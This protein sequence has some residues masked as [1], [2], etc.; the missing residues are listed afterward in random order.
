MVPG[1]SMRTDFRITGPAAPAG[2]ASEFDLTIVAPT[3]VDALRVPARVTATSSSTPIQDAVRARLLAYLREVQAAKLK[4]YKDRTATRFIPL[5]MTSG[6]TLAPRARLAFNHW[7]SLSH[8][9][10]PFLLS[11][12]SMLLV[13]ARAEHF[14]F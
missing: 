1:T 3:S 7:R 9:P 6:G 14:R 10:F 13:R 2:V 5:A 11:H 12:L 8:T 4:K